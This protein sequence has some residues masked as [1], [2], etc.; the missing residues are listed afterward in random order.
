MYLRPFV[1]IC[2]AF[3]LYQKTENECQVKMYKDIGPVIVEKMKM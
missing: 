1:Q 3:S 2:L